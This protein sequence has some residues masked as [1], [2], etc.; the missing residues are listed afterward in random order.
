MPRKSNS[1]SK[2]V[3]EAK[4]KANRCNA[5]FSTGPSPEG[6]ARTRLNAL[7]HGLTA[8]VAWVGQDPARDQEFFRAAW[9]QIAP[10]HALEETSL[11]NLLKARLREY[12]FI[13]V[14]RTVL[15][16]K[17]VCTVGT[18][19]VQLYPF[20]LDPVALKTLEQL[21]RHLTHLSN[22]ADKGFLALLRARGDCQA[23]TGTSTAK[24]TGRPEPD[25]SHPQHAGDRLPDSGTPQGKSAVGQAYPLPGTLEAC[26]A[27]TRL[28]L[29]H[30]DAQIYEA[31]ARNLWAVLQPRSVL[32]GF[33]V[34]DVIQTQWRLDRILEIQHIVL[35]RE[36]ISASQ[37]NCGL[38][39]GFVQD[40]QRVS[41]LE[42]LRQYEA[43]LQKR[44][45][46]RHTLLAKLRK[47][48]WSDDP[49]FGAAAAAVESPPPDQAD[50]P[51]AEVNRSSAPGLAARIT[52]NRGRAIEPVPRLT[53]KPG[54]EPPSTVGAQ[55]DSPPAPAA[56]HDACSDQGQPLPAT[57]ASDDHKQLA[58]AGRTVTSST[59]PDAAGLD[60]TTKNGC[61]TGL[62]YRY[63]TNGEETSP[64]AAQ[65]P[66]D[67]TF[68]SN[69][70]VIISPVS[71]MP[72]TAPIPAAATG[73][74]GCS[75]PAPHD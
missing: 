2:P 23:G 66:Q 37:V 58:A 73:G 49:S 44:L 54:S 31:L 34:T 6:K 19:E 52:G 48:G 55:S 28:V 62:P 27:D 29:P 59:P 71:E 43:V 57:L 60:T 26:L 53:P 9:A 63:G 32:E 56:I 38:A 75:N 18:N 17:P 70:S 40:S 46:K 4:L 1:R 42:R 65:N 30:E 8:R 20:L 61:Q 10:R 14:E 69:G 3:S 12:L 64:S 74:R 24:G 51:S 68:V 25:A 13:E 15:T 16:R 50:S 72:A 67:P 41:A 22:V 45:D 11:A 36:S 7:K 21:V 35:E 39:F 47:E 5:Q 33:L